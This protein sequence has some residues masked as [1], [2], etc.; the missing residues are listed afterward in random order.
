MLNSEKTMFALNDVRDDHIESARSML[1]YK[2]EKGR[3]HLGKKRIV[4]FAL[5][6]ALILS[7][8][9]VCWARLES[10]TCS[11]RTSCFVSVLRVA[12][13]VLQPSNPVSA[14]NRSKVIVT[15]FIRRQML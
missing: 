15:F 13:V 7:L 10:V 2:T 8:V 14:T 4:T 12:R 3:R 1:G 9:V 11:C 6:A 5:A